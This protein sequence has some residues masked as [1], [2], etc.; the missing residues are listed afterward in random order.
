MR[1]TLPGRDR[2]IPVADPVGRSLPSGKDC[3]PMIPRDD[4][5]ESRPPSGSIA[6][7]T[8]RENVND[9]ESVLKAARKGFN[10]HGTERIA[11]RR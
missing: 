6:F 7:S 10:S 8:T 1:S 3:R 5:D 9:P 2:K 4:R 11:G